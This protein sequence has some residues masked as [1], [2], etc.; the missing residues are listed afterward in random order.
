MHRLV[1]L[2]ALLGVCIVMV[3]G[4]CLAM[5]L[6]THNTV[7]YDAFGVCL[8]LGITI[9]VCSPVIGIILMD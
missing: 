6:V 4:V 1:K 3:S 8:I 9:G 2:G 7:Y 5:A